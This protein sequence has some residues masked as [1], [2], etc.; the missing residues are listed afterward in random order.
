MVGTS[1]QS[2][3]EMASDMIKYVVCGMILILYLYVVYLP[4]SASDFCR[5]SIILISCQAFPE[6]WPRCGPLESLDH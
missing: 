3:P 5:R 6:A 1:N 2:V 4:V